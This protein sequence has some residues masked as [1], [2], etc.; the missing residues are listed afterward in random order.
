MSN[1]IIS[2]RENF[3]KN[4]NIDNLSSLDF[5]Y[6]I[7]FFVFTIIIVSEIFLSVIYSSVSFETQYLKAALLIYSVALIKIIDF[8]LNLKINIRH[9]NLKKNFS[10][11]WALFTRKSNLKPLDLILVTTF[12]LFAGLVIWFPNL[13]FLGYIRD[14]CLLTF[15]IQLIIRNRNKIEISK[16]PFELNKYPIIQLVVT[17][18][19][20]LSFNIL[21][22]INILTD[23]FNFNFIFYLTFLVISLTAIILSL[24]LFV[25]EEEIK[26]LNLKIYEAKN[27]QTIANLPKSPLL[28]TL[29]F[30]PDKL[31]RMRLF[32][33]L[34]YSVSILAIFFCY[35]LMIYALN[36]P[37]FASIGSF[38][39]A[40]GLTSLLFITSQKMK[41]IIE[42]QIDE[43]YNLIKMN[44]NDLQIET[45][46]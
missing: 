30:S 28:Q 11:I 43:Y 6:S 24:V 34:Q 31:A 35:I 10:K 36:V 14:F 20:I 15:L 26:Y 25:E 41:G 1:E 44:K 45:A 7:F 2:Y 4:N 3:L 21:Y 17:I 46:I 13:F 19:S 5:L 33:N 8:S 42:E 12:Y 37:T 18:L 16:T 27:Q 40:T 9:R 38:L 39:L 32:N 23:F 29:K 22:T